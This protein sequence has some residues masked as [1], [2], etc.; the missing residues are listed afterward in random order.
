M[1]LERL[2]LSH[3]NLWVVSASSL[4]AFYFD[5]GEGKGVYYL[6]GGLFQVQEFSQPTQRKFHELN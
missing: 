2:N 3:H 4:H 6:F 1:R 5:A